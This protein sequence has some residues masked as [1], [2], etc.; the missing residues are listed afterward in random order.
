MRVAAQIDAGAHSRDHR[1]R[2]HVASGRRDNAGRTFARHPASEH[3]DVLHLR[4]RHRVIAVDGD[5][6]Q[7]VA[8][9]DVEQPNPVVRVDVRLNRRVQRR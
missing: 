6:G 1:R 7:R 4:K 3:A 9:T 8:V 2:R 5:L